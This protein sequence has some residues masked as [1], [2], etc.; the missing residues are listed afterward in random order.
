M[1]SCIPSKYVWKIEKFS[2]LGSKTHYSEIFSAC[3]LWWTLSIE[4][5]GLHE[6]F[7]SPEGLVTFN[8][9]QFVIGLSPRRTGP[10]YVEYS[11]AVVNQKDKKQTIKHVKECEMS[12]DQITLCEAMSRKELNP[13]KGFIF[14]D[15]LYI[16]VEIISAMKMVESLNFSFTESQSFIGVGYSFKSS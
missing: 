16:K 14:D 11:L 6:T 5:E 8:G 15:I 12:K 1:T 13:E 2:S 3:G 9:E 7:E 4:P 10:W